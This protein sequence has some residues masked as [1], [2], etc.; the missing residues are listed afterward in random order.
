MTRRPQQGFASQNP[1]LEIL[2]LDH[3]QGLKGATS[4]GAARMPL[5]RAPPPTPINSQHFLKR[6]LALFLRP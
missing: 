1:A 3:F 5:E 2:K 4:S 6:G